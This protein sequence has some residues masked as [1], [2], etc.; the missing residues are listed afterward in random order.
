MVFLRTVANFPFITSFHWER[1]SSVGQSEAHLRWI[2]P[3]DTPDGEYRISHYGYYKNI[4]GTVAPYSGSTQSFT[5][6]TAK[7]FVY[8]GITFTY[9]GFSIWQVGGK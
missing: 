2:V 6:T 4:D 7:P 3:D 5:V 8:Y 1:T 9:F